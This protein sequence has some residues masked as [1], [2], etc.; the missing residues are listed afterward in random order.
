MKKG[1]ARRLKLLR[2]SYG[3]SQ[4][5]LAR[6]L[7][8]PQSYVA[9]WEAEAYD[10]SEMLKKR[11]ARFFQVSPGWLME[12][13]EPVFS[14]VIF[15]PIFFHMPKRGFDAE[16]W[17]DTAMLAVGDGAVVDRVAVNADNEDEAVFLFARES[18]LRLFMHFGAPSRGSRSPSGTDMEGVL[19]RITAGS[20]TGGREGRSFKVYRLPENTFRLISPLSALEG[21]EKLLSTTIP[22]E[23][24]KACKNEGPARETRLGELVGSLK[25]E[26]RRELKD[27]DI[28]NSACRFLLSIDDEDTLRG[29][30]FLVP[31]L[32]KDLGLERSQVAGLSAG[33]LMEKIRDYCGGSRGW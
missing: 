26:A 22:A 13:I 1:F 3:I 5:R 4:V 28:D 16:K 6:V 19:Q 29:I 27:R 14:G 7:N 8:I 20:T 30:L 32:M 33:D 12:D 15:I 9:K 24:K 17:L 18:D 31:D 21:I 23:L 25:D 10:P 11:V 2:D